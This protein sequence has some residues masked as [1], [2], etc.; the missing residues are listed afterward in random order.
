MFSCVHV[1][2]FVRSCS[3]F[4]ALMCRLSCLHQTFLRSCPGFRAF[5][6]LLFVHVQTFERFLMFPDYVIL[7]ARR[8]HR[9]FIFGL[10]RLAAVWDLNLGMLDYFIFA[11]VLDIT[12]RYMVPSYERV[13]A[14]FVCVIWR[15]NAAYRQGLSLHAE[16]VFGISV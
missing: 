11:S 14:I 10:D 8:P 9:A 12:K 1:Q 7:N 16:F 3:D 6:R 15:R 2:T 5:T 13:T 4:R